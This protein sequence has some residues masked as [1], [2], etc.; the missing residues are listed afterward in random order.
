MGREDLDVLADAL[1]AAARV[2]RA[3]AV[4]PR[5]RTT[6]QASAAAASDDEQRRAVL[7]VREAAEELRISRSTI[8]GLLAR[9]ELPSIRVGS[10][11]LI[12]RRELVDWLGRQHI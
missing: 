7:T 1:E 12:V 4:Q 8:Y 5:A 11:R 6:L 3:A 2:L 10:R 9:G